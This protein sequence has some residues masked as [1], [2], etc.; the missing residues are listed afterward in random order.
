MLHHA[1]QSLRPW[2]F[3]NVSK[4][5][6]SGSETNILLVISP[7][8]L[9]HTVESTLGRLTAFPYE[10]RDAYAFPQPPS[11][12]LIYHTLAVLHAYSISC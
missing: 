5:R 10:D 8:L 2:L 6:L 1:G 7:S 4:L 9:A 12:V 11:L 3:R